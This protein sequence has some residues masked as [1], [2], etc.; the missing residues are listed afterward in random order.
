MHLRGAARRHERARDRRRR[1]SAGPRPFILPL[2]TGV[3]GETVWKIAEGL[4]AALQRLQEVADRG[5]MGPF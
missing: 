1:R 2:F 4:S 3:R 5:P